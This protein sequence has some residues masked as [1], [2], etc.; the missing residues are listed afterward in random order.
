L[1]GKEL[2][3]LPK[4]NILRYC[5]YCNKEYHKPR[6]RSNNRGYCSLN[7]WI[8]FESEKFFVYGIILVLLTIVIA[9]I[10]I[11][12]LMI[13]LLI[14]FPALN[15]LGER[16]II[17]AFMVI[18]ITEFI[19]LLVSAM[20]MIMGI[21]GYIKRSS[22]KMI[23]ATSTMKKRKNVANITDKITCSYCNKEYPAETI[24]E[25]CLKCGTCF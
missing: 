21:Y 4:I 9:P 23:T 11:F 8:A 18:A 7:C 22:I 13:I 25:R 10:V 17:L 20:L 16:S 14:V 24:H 5:K 19:G 15:S 2:N 3:S 1:S 6:K 12:L